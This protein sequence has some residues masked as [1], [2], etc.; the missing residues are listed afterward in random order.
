MSAQARHANVL[1]SVDGGQA[2][3][4]I[5]RHKPKDALDIYGGYAPTLG[6]AL[7]CAPAVGQGSMVH[8]QGQGHFEVA[9][10][11]EP[12]ATGWVLLQLR[13]ATLSSE[14]PNNPETEANHG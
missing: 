13:E 4:A 9:Q 6:F 7:A 2:F 14:Q 5:Y 10:P 8:V 12:D 1:C 11:I 3:A